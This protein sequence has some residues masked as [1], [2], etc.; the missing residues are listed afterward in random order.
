MTNF[1]T[2]ICHHCGGSEG[3][4]MFETMQCPLNGHEAWYGHK[5]TWMT[6]TFLDGG[7]YLL[8]CTASAMYEALEKL[9]KNL[10]AYEYLYHPDSNGMVEACRQSLKN[11]KP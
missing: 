7:L 9:L 8:T 4:H 10:D 2:D 5:Q 3:I 6:S 1:K 11:A